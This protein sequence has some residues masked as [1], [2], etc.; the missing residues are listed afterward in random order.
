MFALITALTLVTP[1]TAV[2]A[3]AGISGSTTSGTWVC[4]DTTRTKTSEWEGRISLAATTLL[5]S[6]LSL[7]LRNDDCTAF[8][9]SKT[10]IQSE[11]NVRKNFTTGIAAGKKFNM[12]ACCYTGAGS[13]WGGNLRW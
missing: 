9:T 6:S 2:A 5:G 10:W 1:G 4:Y 8:T 11:I 12:G 7:R 13:H 3:S